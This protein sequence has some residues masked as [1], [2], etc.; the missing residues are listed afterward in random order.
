MI[1]KQSGLKIHKTTNGMRKEDN[2]DAP[3]QHRRILVEEEIQK[4]IAAAPRRD[5]EAG[6][7]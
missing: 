1:D 3:P 7:L 5:R 6:E 2:L 4:I